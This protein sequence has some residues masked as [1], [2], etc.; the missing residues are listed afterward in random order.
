MRRVVSV[1]GKSED[2]EEEGGGDYKGKTEISGESLFL[3]TD[4]DTRLSLA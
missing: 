4:R 1:W 3:L 2:E